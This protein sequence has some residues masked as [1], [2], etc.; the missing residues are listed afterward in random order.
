MK[1][2]RSLNLKIY[3]SKLKDNNIISSINGHKKRNDNEIITIINKPKINLKENQFSLELLMKL[4][5]QCKLYDKP[6]I[7]LLR[8]EINL[9]EDFMNNTLKL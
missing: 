8:E 2:T 1:H 9:I 4:K 7:I 6:N 3:I 5:Y